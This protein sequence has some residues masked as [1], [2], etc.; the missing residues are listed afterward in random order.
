MASVLVQL[1]NVSFAY[2]GW[3]DYLLRNISF[4]IQSGDRIGLL[5]YNGSGKTTLLDVIAGIKEPT[6]GEVIKRCNNLFYL[7]QEDYAYGSLSIIEYLIQTEPKFYELHQR[8]IQCENSNLT[9]SLEYANIVYEFNKQG[10]YDFIKRIEKNA[11]LFGFSA[12]DFSRKI[13]SLSGGEKRILKIITGFIHNFD[14][15][16]LDEPTNYLDDRGIEL[17][18]RA[19][20]FSSSAFLIVSHDRWFLDQMVGKVI[21]I[22]QKTAKIYNGNYSKFHRTKQ[23]E[24]TTKLKKKEKIETEIHH[25]K[26]IARNYRIWGLRKEKE[27]VGAGDKGFIS[28]RAAKLL[29][30]VKISEERIKK[31]ISEF[32]KTKPYIEKYYDFWFEKTDIPRGSCLS[33]NLL[34]KKFGD[35]TLFQD[36]SFTV[37][38]GEKI[39]IAGPN[40]SGKTTLLK[41]VMGKES[42]DSGE[43]VW[44]NLSKIGYLPQVWDSPEDFI[45]VD[46]LFSEEQKEI[47]N[48]LIGTLKVM[49]MGNVFPKR[50]GEL[51]EGQKRKIKLVQLILNKPNILILDEP[52]THL[53]YQTVEFLEKAL[54]EYN[55]TVILISH[56]RFL[57]DRVTTRRITV[58]S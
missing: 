4:T 38:W 18:I 42:P 26:D 39:T 25:L 21:E 2:P 8:M 57:R 12:A 28:H 20:R 3:K 19:I 11:A 50:L 43:V 22:E 34:S 54:I 31:R 9:D 36:F 33:V 52:T 27:K 47:A 24:I 16:L 6:E 55:G 23:I 10:G 5:G 51:S 37:D 40:G 48:H 46:S 1:N 32:E 14:L 49:A 17:L 7:K 44:H 30:R 56:D 15:Y 13:D 45:T 29:K 41:I 53:D 35:K 58:G